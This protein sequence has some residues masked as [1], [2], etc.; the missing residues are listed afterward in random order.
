V[1][2]GFS[3]HHSG[4]VKNVEMFGDGKLIS[5]AF[6]GTIRLWV[7]LF[8]LFL[9]AVSCACDVHVCAPVP[10]ARTKPRD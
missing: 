4:W 1:S 3:L 6:D 2:N 5:T 10:R 8:T 9:L 7:Q